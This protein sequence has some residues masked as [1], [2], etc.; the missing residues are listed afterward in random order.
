MKL[1]S[2]LTAS[3]VGMGLFVGAAQAGVVIGEDKTAPYLIS[4]PAAACFGDYTVT[5]APPITP[6]QDQVIYNVYEADNADMED[7]VLIQTDTLN[8]IQVSGKTDGETYYAVE[9]TTGSEVGP[10]LVSQPVKGRA[11]CW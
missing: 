7:A 4:T 6:I 9:E 5:W 2:I 10:A 11:N 8:F 1:S 3:I